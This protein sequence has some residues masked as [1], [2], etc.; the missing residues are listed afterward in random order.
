M[1]K[2]S[3]D[4]ARFLLP[5]LDADEDVELEHEEQRYSAEAIRSSYSYDY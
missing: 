2:A 3:D 1:V 4:A 5:L